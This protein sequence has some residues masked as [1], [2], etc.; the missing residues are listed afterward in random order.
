MGN[1]KYN[2]DKPI[3][4][5]T[6]VPSGKWGNAVNQWKAKHGISGEVEKKRSLKRRS[7]N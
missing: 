4:T 3:M 5:E 2:A 1:F 6:D 7:T